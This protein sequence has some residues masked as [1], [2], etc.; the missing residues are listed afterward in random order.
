MLVVDDNSVNQRLATLLLERAGYRVDA[1]GNGAEAVHA[2]RQ[3][4]YDAVLMDCEMPVMDGYAAAAEIRRHEAGRDRVPIVAVSASTTP[5]DVDRALAAGMDAHVSKPI[6]R[7]E[8]IGTLHALLDDTPPPS[9]L[10]PSALAQLRELDDDGAALRALAE[11]FLTSGPGKVDR[12]AA[13]VRAGDLPGVASAA[14]SLRGSAG[15]FGATELVELAGT[16][17]RDARDGEAPP[18]DA[19]ERIEQLFDSTVQALRVEIGDHPP[20]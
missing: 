8:L 17:E 2:L 10:D 18:P 15:T 4:R 6:D 5:G 11:L 19:V 3:R 20:A 14:H 1:V 7:D 9:P 12:L 16:I 13:A